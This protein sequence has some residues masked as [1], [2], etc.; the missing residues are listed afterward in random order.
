V[1]ADGIMDAFSETNS[2]TL[3]FIGQTSPGVWQDVRQARR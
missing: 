1:N 3:Q 2:A